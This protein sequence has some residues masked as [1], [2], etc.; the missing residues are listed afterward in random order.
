[1][2]IQTRTLSSVE[3]DYYATRSGLP[4]RSPLNDHKRTVWEKVVGG[5]NL[6]LKELELRWLQSATSNSSSS[7][8][9]QWENMVGTYGAGNVAKTIDENRYKWYCQNFNL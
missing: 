4:N 3:H 7:L 5:G 8:V 9:E 6:S 1:M 2:A